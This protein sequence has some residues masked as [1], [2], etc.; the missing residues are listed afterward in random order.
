MMI[1]ALVVGAAARLAAGGPPDRIASPAD[2]GLRPA[3]IPVSA[4]TKV[5]YLVNPLLNG[6]EA[7]AAALR[8]PATRPAPAGWSAAPF[9]ESEVRTLTAPGRPGGTAAHDAVADVVEVFFKYMF[10]QVP[11]TERGLRRLVQEMNREDFAL[12]AVDV[13]PRILV[14]GGGKA[15]ALEVDLTLRLFMVHVETDRER[16]LRWMTRCELCFEDAAVGR[17]VLDPETA[18]PAALAAATLDALK[19]KIAVSF[20]QT[21]A[22][23]RPSGKIDEP[24][25]ELIE[26][27]I[28]VPVGRDVA[29][30]S[31]G[32]IL[33]PG[34][35]PMEETR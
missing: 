5:A 35:A 26:R 13:T 17:C 6:S 7:L 29:G 2:L 31:A 16:N 32:P 14:E 33:R 1:A 25:R 3:D 23:R 30:G 8:A 24:R 4:E 20:S 9:S 27:S 15:R 21:P 22:L 10:S 19:G 18:P 34:I 28:S 12:A 11:C